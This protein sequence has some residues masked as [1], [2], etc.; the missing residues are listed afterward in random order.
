MLESISTLSHH[1]LKTYQ[2]PYLRYFLKTTELENRFSIIVGQR[3]I[4][5]STALIQQLLAHS[6][7]DLL[8]DTI[9]YVQ[10]DHF[11]TARYTLYELAEE[12]SK[13]GGE[14]IAF[15]EVHKYRNW[16]AELKSIYDT[17]PSLKILASGSSVLEIRQGSHD[18]SR[19]ALVYRMWGMSF[20]EFLELSLG[21]NLP[22]VPLAAII[23]DHLP[24]AHEITSKIE[25][26]GKK[27]LPLFQ[28]YLKFGHYPYFSEFTDV[29][30]FHMILEQQV[31]TTVE[32]DIM[33][34]YP[35]LAGESIRK[36][37]KLLTIIAASVPLTP[38]LK[39]LMRMTD[40]GDHRT[41]KTYLKYLEDGGIIRQLRKAGRAYDSLEKP[42]KIYLDNANQLYALSGGQVNPGNVRETFFAAALA[43][44]HHLVI[45]HKGDFLVDEERLFE[46]GGR[47]KSARQIAGLQDAYLVRDD[48][49]Y[50]HQH[51]I[52]LWLFGMLY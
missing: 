51:K 29:S 52:P 21:L 6:Q 41:L 2:R 15:D 45:P 26:L 18:L 24:I 1:F 22:A 16:S 33:A 32:A 34:V 14:L 44:G 7:G 50:G 3:G 36:L 40:I 37:K 42:E 43:P 23:A 27:I 9:L 8:A 47:N 10:A 39:K 4:G 5:K 17:F 20:R 31:H 13:Y 30:Q 28:A 38:D 35:A 11:I 19:R 48:I 25:A 49:E 12:F 46:V